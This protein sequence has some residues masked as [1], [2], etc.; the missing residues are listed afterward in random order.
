[1]IKI[2]LISSY[3]YYHQ[4][5]NVEAPLPF[6]YNVSARSPYWIIYAIVLCN[7]TILFFHIVNVLLNRAR[8]VSGNLIMHFYSYFIWVYLR[9]TFA[10]KWKY[11]RARKNCNILSRSLAEL[12]L[13]LYNL[14]NEDSASKNMNYE[15]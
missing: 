7:R 13:W 8:N 2:N 1:M 10:S 4:C 9:L 15:L 12:S 5:R 14:T 3:Y 11:I 6:N